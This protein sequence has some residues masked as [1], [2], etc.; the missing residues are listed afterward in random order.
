MDQGKI[1]QFDTPQNIAK[2]P[3]NDFVISLLHSAKVQK[4]FLEE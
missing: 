3:A 2:N 1:Q 4:V